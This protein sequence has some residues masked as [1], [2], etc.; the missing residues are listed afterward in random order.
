MHLV[1]NGVS[2]PP[3]AKTLVTSAARCWRAARDRGEPV[4]QVLHAMLARHDGGMLAPVFDSLMN[5]YEAAL[6]RAVT[7]GCVPDLSPDEHLLLGLLDGSRRRNACI[8]CA[9]GPA[10]ALD[11]AICSAR[12]MMALTLSR[13]PGSV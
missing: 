6:G 11:C 3:L 5:L 1:A 4:Q 2:A 9:E 7:V 12:I 10:T 8:D 13:S